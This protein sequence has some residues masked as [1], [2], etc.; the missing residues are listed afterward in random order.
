MRAKTLVS[1]AALLLATSI[2]AVS[3][4]AASLEGAAEK[5]G[6]KTAKSLE[7]SGAG[8][9][10]QFGQAPV[11]GGPWPQFD[12]S[13][14]A[15]QIDFDAGAQHVALARLQTIVPERAR[16]APVEQKVDAW[17]NGDKAWNVGPAP[18]AAPD[19]APAATPAFAAVEER[20]AEIWSTPQGFLKAALAH[21]AKSEPVDGGVKVS[22]AVGK[23]KYEGVIDAQDQLA[24]VKTW[25]DSPVLGD[26]PYETK[27]SGYKS[28]DGVLFP[29]EIARSEG[30]HPILKIAV[31]SA[32][33]NAVPA[34]STPDNIAS[35]QPPAVTVKA[36][37]VADNVF[38]LTGGTHHSVAVI[39]GDHIVLIE[40][41][42][43]EERS[44]AVLK[45]LEEVAPGKPV[46]TVVA[47]HLHFDHSGGLRTFVDAGATLV[48][49]ELAKPYL[50]AA[51]A[52]PRSLN[53]DRLAA[54]NKA[55]VFQTW[56]DE[57]SLADGQI[58]LHRLAGSGH[59]D[60]LGLIFLPKAKLAVEADAYTPLAEG[61]PA[62][63]SVNPYAL[64][65]LENIRKLNLDVE[66]IA[67][68]HGPRLVTLDDL[69]AYVGEK[70]A[71]N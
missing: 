1:L 64:N 2:G 62:P 26:T 46:K 47:S 30:G 9:W 61:A 36:E 54:S 39:D 18:G 51:W 28:F 25:I 35:A 22:F 59:S 66:K 56:K 42:L 33:L 12:V 45:K 32:K 8:Q 67:A 60:D 63:K 20:T 38:Y 71:S 31:S 57:L 16:P 6:A 50:Q 19:A 14:Y 34:I 17:L 70:H 58:K 24:S 44:L 65:L 53:P 7:F 5:L 4:Q 52:N 69:K 29:A 10:F 48:V 37:K 68:L 3:A 13:R 41:P 21:G 11:P 27:F 15:A 43:N 40:A 49:H 55:P 23:H